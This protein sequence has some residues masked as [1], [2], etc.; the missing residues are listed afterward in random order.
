MQLKLESVKQQNTELKSELQALS[1]RYA[2]LKSDR[3]EEEKL[4]GLMR[5]YQELQSE[6]QRLQ[7]DHYL[8]IYMNSFYILLEKRYDR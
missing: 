5:Q 1:D 3:S 4:E 8:V 2:E 7:Q 6:Y